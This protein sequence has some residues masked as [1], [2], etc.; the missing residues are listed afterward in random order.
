MLTPNY[1]GPMIFSCVSKTYREHIEILIKSLL[2]AGCDPSRVEAGVRAFEIKMG[3]GNFSIKK[4]ARK[5]APP[6]D[7]SRFSASDTMNR[8]IATIFNDIDIINN[9]VVNIDGVNYVIGQAYKD[10]DHLLGDASDN[11]VGMYNIKQRKARG[12]TDEER[13]HV[14]E[15]FG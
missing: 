2:E 1:L 10:D 3:M 9:N 14:R 13:D 15:A 6:S 11:I 7:K 12:F 8:N 5:I 4:P